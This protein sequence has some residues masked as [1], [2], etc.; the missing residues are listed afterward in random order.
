MNKALISSGFPQS[1]PN[2]PHLFSASCLS[3]PLFFLIFFIPSSSLDGANS[4]KARRT[5]C[6][7]GEQ[8]D[9][10]GTNTGTMVSDT[11]KT[12]SQWGRHASLERNGKS[13]KLIER[14]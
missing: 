7:R 11:V 9:E 10:G 14:V 8:E 2:V 12:P 6:V 13:E 3:I 5:H 1:N 4:V